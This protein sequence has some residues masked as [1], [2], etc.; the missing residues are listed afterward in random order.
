[1]VFTKKNFVKG[2]PVKEDESIDYSE[3]DSMDE[4]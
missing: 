4:M 2:K 1:M 3:E